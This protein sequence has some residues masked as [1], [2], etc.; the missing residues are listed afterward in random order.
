MTFCFLVFKLR[1]YARP[2]PARTKA[3]AL[4]QGRGPSS[5]TVARRSRDHCVINPWVSVSLS[6]VTESVCIRFLSTKNK[7]LLFISY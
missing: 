2:I 7:L 1:V 4:I 3:T 5:A 6:Y